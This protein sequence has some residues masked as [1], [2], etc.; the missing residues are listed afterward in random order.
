[1]LFVSVRVELV[2][3]LCLSGSMVTTGG[4]K[5]AVIPFGKPVT[6]KARGA[7]A[8]PDLIILTL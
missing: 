3:G 5:L 7:A 6:E 8:S 2:T 4:E 1:M